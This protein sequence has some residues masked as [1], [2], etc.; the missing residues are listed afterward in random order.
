[1][2]GHAVC[3]SVRQS[4]VNRRRGQYIFISLDSA[5]AIYSLAA[6]PRYCSCHVLH[7]QP[8]PTAEHTNKYAYYSAV[9][10]ND[11]LTLLAAQLQQQLATRSAHTQPHRA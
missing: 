4:V 9:R 2:S 8:R 6:Q 10:A 3:Q 7:T 11:T 5:A 1:M